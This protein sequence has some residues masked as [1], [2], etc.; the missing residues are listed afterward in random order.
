M[1]CV[2]KEW[3]DGQSS[4]S[5]FRNRF[6]KPNGYFEFTDWLGTPRTITFFL[7]AYGELF[8]RWIYVR[9]AWYEP[10]WFISVWIRGKE[11]VSLGYSG[12]IQMANARLAKKIAKIAIPA[13]W[14]LFR[15]SNLTPPSPVIGFLSSP[16]QAMNRCACWDYV[17]LLDL[18]VE[19]SDGYS[20]GGWNFMVCCWRRCFDWNT[21]Y[22]FV[23]GM[24]FWKRLEQVLF[25]YVHFVP[26]STHFR[27]VRDGFL[28][29]TG[30]GFFLY[31][32]FVPDSTQFSFS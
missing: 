31:V 20:R 6:W 29:E 14:W 16:P 13:V 30:T 25:L 18:P 19:W 21:N 23:F 27:F 1:Q 28:K 9:F 26:D 32:H 4:L 24:A 2:V 7:P 5:I 11:V 12:F 17:V 22:A 10:Y 8:L 15:W 3:R